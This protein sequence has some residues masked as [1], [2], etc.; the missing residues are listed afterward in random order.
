MMK[1]QHKKLVP[2]LF[3][4]G[5]ST[6]LL[7]ITNFDRMGS[8]R[9]DPRN[10]ELATRLSSCDSYKDLAGDIRVGH[11]LAG[12]IIFDVRACKAD[13]RKVDPLHLLM[14]FGDKI[15]DEK[16]DYLLIASGGNEVY[17]LPKSDLDELAEQY[18][19]GARIWALD[20]WPERLRKP[21]GERVF[22]EWSGGVLGVLQAQLEDLGVAL[23]TWLANAETR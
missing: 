14:Q 15:K 13:S 5:L 11:T 17:R 19:L 6:V 1:S 3:C 12:N 22:E 2:P 7:V 8:N 21:T 4:A 20:H 23:R 10:L 9:L 16:I 18:R